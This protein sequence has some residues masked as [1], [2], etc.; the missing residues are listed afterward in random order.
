LAY[1]VSLL[2]ASIAR[3]FGGMTGWKMRSYSSLN[4][5]A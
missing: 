1:S 3:Y 5:V 4:A 2:L